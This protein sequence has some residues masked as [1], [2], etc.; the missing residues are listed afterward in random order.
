[1]W[2]SIFQAC[3]IMLGSV[4]MFSKD[5]FT[6]IVTITFSALIVCEILNVFSEVHQVNYK[7]ILSSI[8]TF[9]VYFSSIALFKQYFDTSYITW[10]FIFK[11]V[12]ITLASWAPLHLA[13]L[14]N[15]CCDPS[16]QQKIM[17]QAH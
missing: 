15:D 4:I 3:I 9:L 16:E 14:L 5:S 7:M 12:A 13:R 8:L 2:K 17:R 11:V 10:V 6:N 1:M